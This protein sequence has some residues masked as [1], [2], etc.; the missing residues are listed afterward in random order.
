M[1]VDVDRMND[2][3]RRAVASALVAALLLAVLAAWPG[4][5]GGG[6]EVLG[7]RWWGTDAPETRADKQSLALEAVGRI[8]RHHAPADHGKHPVY[9]PAVSFFA[10]RRE[11]AWRAEKDEEERRGVAQQLRETPARGPSGQKLSPAQAALAAKFNQLSGASSTAYSDFKKGYERETGESSAV[12]SPPRRARVAPADA[13]GR[14]VGRHGGRD[15]RPRADS[16]G[17]EWD[18]RRPLED[19]QLPPRAEARKLEAR[20]M[21]PMPKQV[22]SRRGFRQ[23]LEGGHARGSKE[24]ALEAEVDNLKRKLGEVEGEVAEVR[25]GW[26]GGMHVEG[27]STQAG[28]IWDGTERRPVFPGASSL[29]EGEGGGS[30]TAEG[31][32]VM[33]GAPGE[34]DYDKY[35][36]ELDKFKDPTPLHYRDD[37]AGGVEVHTREDEIRRIREYQKKIAEEQGQMRKDWKKLMENPPD[38]TEAT[39]P[40]IMDPDSFPTEGEAFHKKYREMKDFKAAVE[41][42]E[43]DP[44][45]NPMIVLKAHHL[46]KYGIPAPESD[47][48]YVWRQWY[49]EALD[50]YHVVRHQVTD[51]ASGNWHDY[52]TD[53][54]MHGIHRPGAYKKVWRTRDSWGP[55]KPHTPI[56]TSPDANFTL[57]HGGGEV[58]EAEGGEVRNETVAEATEAEAGTPSNGEVEAEGEGHAEGGDP[59]EAAAANGDVGDGEAATETDEDETAGAQE[60]APVA[61]LSAKV[62]TLEKKLD[63]VVTLLEDRRR[64][65]RLQVRAPQRLAQQ[66]QRP[67]R[68]AYLPSAAERDR[69]A[70]E[71]WEGAPGAGAKT[72]GA[73]STLAAARQTLK[74]DAV[75]KQLRSAA[76]AA[77]LSAL[78]SEKAAVSPAEEQIL[79]HPPKAVLNWLSSAFHAAAASPGMKHKGARHSQSLVAAKSSTP[80]T[81]NKPSA[82]Q[83]A[84]PAAVQKMI[85]AGAWEGGAHG[86]AS[87]T[88]AG[89]A[90]SPPLYSAADAR[91]DAEA[92]SAAKSA[93]ASAEA[94]KSVRDAPDT[95]VRAKTAS[96]GMMLTGPDPSS[97]PK[98]TRSAAPVDPL[99]R[100]EK[101][102]LVKGGSTAAQQADAVSSR[103]DVDP[104]GK[105]DRS[106]VP[107]TLTKKFVG[108]REMYVPKYDKKRAG[109]DG[110]GWLW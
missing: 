13:S 20:H 35:G 39:R 3:M 73:V 82:S 42:F 54:D 61:A 81:D 50:K 14:V 68:K 90:S 62:D 94:V 40:D 27:G 91:E 25:H 57:S 47:N 11:Q 109:G 107:K 58:E 51:M 74:A 78:K 85:R 43:H 23:T 80:A 83:S 18:A 89:A 22:R 53:F 31:G 92:M 4:S 71:G 87:P 49:R 17:S 38:V 33:T 69:L 98:T 88:S 110:W 28:A 106:Q 56:V 19:D 76:T 60:K 36:V 15:K 95:V 7:E 102:I 6:E 72:R 32:G 8:L 70:G 84:A 26:E 34:K 48:I 105:T 55:G 52:D 29:D 10:K 101:A 96:H 77:A 44:E 1:E 2:M 63:N 65:A 66:Q 99:G 24:A 37:I 64:A 46:V 97:S 86:A 21:L 100:A 75:P 9:W 108:G 5:R 93:M 12:R 41:A 59:G 67:L 45:F 30:A 103:G 79:S 104:E 16:W